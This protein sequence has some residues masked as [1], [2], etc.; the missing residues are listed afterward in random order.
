L[1]LAP[2]TQ[3]KDDTQNP[4]TSP[5]PST[6]RAH[7]DEVVKSMMDSPVGG[8]TI[9][10][11]GDA[12]KVTDLYDLDAQPSGNENG[13]GALDIIP[14]PTSLSLLGLA[15][16]GGLYRRHRAAARKLLPVR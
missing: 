11:E 15:L 2:I 6:R 10:G 3:G 12:T 14:E 5:T 1:L 13:G 16:A 9:Y 7:V 4:F 8:E